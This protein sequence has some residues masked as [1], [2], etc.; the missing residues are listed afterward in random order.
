MA[1]ETTGAGI[2]ARN[3]AGAIT[4]MR[5]DEL[6]SSLAIGIARGQMELDRACMQIAE[7]MS[8]AQVA[9][10]KRPGSTEPD[11]MSLIELGFTPNFYQFVDTVIEV[12]VAVSTKFQEEREQAVGVMQVLSAETAQQSSYQAT[13]QSAS[14]GG[15]S[16]WGSSSSWGI[17]WGSVSSSSSGGY[18]GSSYS[19]SSGAQVASESS[20]KSK[21]LEMTTVDAKYASTYNYAVE[22]SSVVKTKIVPVPPPTVFEE[23][24]RAKVQ[25]RRDWEKLVRLATE[26][27]AILQGQVA[28]VEQILA[29]LGAIEAIPEGFIS[30]DDTN[31]GRAQKALT[32]AR[33]LKESHDAITNEH[34]ALSRSVQ[35][36][37]TSDEKIAGVVQKAAA[38]RT[39][40]PD[41]YEPG[42]PETPTI[43]ETWNGLKGD[44]DGYRGALVAVL[45]KL[46]AI[47]AQQTTPPQQG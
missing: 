39:Y 33:R 21:A 29:T 13:S 41:S 44:A 27:T 15:G 1:D 12:R 23:I 47:G 24:I 28:L 46:K 36:R 43:V 26:A 8:Q 45:D 18:S 37:K 6:I 42:A 22:A 25:E 7:F 9:F 16:S 4:S 40:F 20:A 17:G 10:G 14:S 30:N 19:R 38:F 5:L 32:D 31:R 35:D 2:E 34:W 3:V 11:L